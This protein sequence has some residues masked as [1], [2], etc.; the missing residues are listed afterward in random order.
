MRKV[1]II[2]NIFNPL[3]EGEKQF[4]KEEILLHQEDDLTQ[5]TNWKK[6]GYTVEQF[7]SKSSFSVLK[8]FVTSLIAE[9][10]K[11]SS[12]NFNLEKYHRWVNDQQHFELVNHIY[13]ECAST[14]LPFKKNL[15]TERIS[16]ICKIPL[17]NKDNFYHLSLFHIRIVRPRSKDNNPFHRD[18]WLDNLKNAIN[19]YVP[20]TGSNRNSSLCIVSG[21]HH[22][23]ESEVE[24]TIHGAKVNG[25]IY[26]VPAVTGAKRKLKI[27]RPNPKENEVLVFSPYLIHGGAVNLNKDTTRVSI[28]MRFWRNTKKINR[29]KLIQ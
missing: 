23:K 1:K 14:L 19:I 8:N 15:I 28:E 11:I 9:K 26:S 13:K 5:N 10:L 12:E 18:V 21:S 29:L 24:R 17:T 20:V 6:K 27:I 7:L 22:W 2:E 3:I 16:S 25:M 4:G